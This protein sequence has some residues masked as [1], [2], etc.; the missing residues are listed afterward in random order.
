MLEVLSELFTARNKDERY[1]TYT[2]DYDFYVQ[3]IIQ[4][5]LPFQTTSLSVQCYK[6]NTKQELIAFEC[7]WYRVFEGKYSEIKEADG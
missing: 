2:G 5:S 4:G 6:N 1:V 3:P 7:K